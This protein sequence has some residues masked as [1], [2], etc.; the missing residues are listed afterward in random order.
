MDGMEPNTTL[1]PLWE[2][3]KERLNKS[4]IAGASAAC[5]S[6]L[7]LDPLNS[8]AHMMLGDISRQRDEY[9][10]ATHHAL[11]A[12]AKMGPQS[13]K[14]IASVSQ[15]LISVGEYEQAVNLIRKVNPDKLP[16]P[17][18][19]VEFSQQLSLVEQHADALRFMDAAVRFG[20]K[21]DSVHYLRGNYLKFLGRMDE[22]AEEYERGLA[23][24]PNFAYAHWALSD[25]G[26][27]GNR[28]L[29]VSRIRASIAATAADHPNIAY[30]HYALFR[31]LDAT[32]DTESA[33][34]ALEAGFRCKR[35]SVTYDP[36]A[37][38]S[39]FEQV[40]Q[41]CGPGFAADVPTGTA[42]Q[43]P[44]F[45]LGMPRTGTT[46]LERILGGH[47]Q[48]T[49][50][51][52]LNDFHMQ[53]KWASD[54][55]SRGFLDA[56]GLER[57][58]GIDFAQLGNRYL[59]HVA[60]RAPSTPYFSDKN[61]GNFLMIGLILRALPHAKIVNLRRNP[62]DSCFSNL[63]QLFAGDSHPFSYDFAGLA[64]RYRNYSQLMTHWHAI[65]PGRVLDVHYEDMVSDPDSAART[66][67]A[68]CGLSYDSGQIR[69]ESNATPVSTA[70][71]AQVRQ[72]IHARNID[73]WK[74]YAKQLAPLQQLLESAAD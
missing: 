72:P 45:V 2:L 64:G 63:K 5:Q 74:R 43:T 47:E 57:L 39:F 3:A 42:A 53:F 30:L 13:L 34:Q 40:A 65:A 41:A 10:L 68:Y 25:L 61:P 50:C 70:S 22:A 7:K 59:Q 71:S 58:P 54:H 28:D 56:V 36:Q 33:W 9:R 4:D 32:D 67:M 66:L 52:E 27:R 17:A 26:L 46:L 31:E 35:A 12:A 49:L 62:M 29:R 1:E 55:N 21:A 24:N 6:L 69:M 11:Q 48:I 18:F 51:G 15:R 20:A 14:H 8:R 44:I 60:W 38:R 37:E 23:V 16:A 73:G 19:L